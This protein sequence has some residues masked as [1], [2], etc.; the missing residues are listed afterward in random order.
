MDI[1]PQIIEFSVIAQNAKVPRD[2]KGWSAYL[3]RDRWD[4]WSSYCTQFYL[5]I[6]DSEGNH[7]EIGHVKIGQ[8]GLKAGSGRDPNLESL[9]RKP[10]MPESFEI[11]GEDFFSVGQDE[12]YY[13]NLTEIGEEVRLLVLVALKDV[14]YDSERWSWAKDEDVTD[15]SLLRS[16]TSSTV[17]GQ[18]RRLAN[19]DARVTRY[20]FS[21]IPPKREG[22]GERR[23]TLDFSVNPKSPIPTNIHVL[24]GRNGVGK[25][26]LLSLMT[27]ALVA[28]KAS[29]RQSGSFEMNEVGGSASTF[30]NVV[31]VSFSAFDDSE[32]FDDRKQGSDS[33][34]FA[35]I[36]LKGRRRGSSP[37]R[38]KSPKALADD[39]VKSL[40]ICRIGAR[41]NRWRDV[42]SIL[43]SDPI[44]KSVQLKSVIDAD[45]ED[46]DTCE[47]VFKIFSLLSSGHK[48]VLL[49][50]TRLVEKVEERTLVLIDEPEGHLHPP[51]LSA[52]TRAISG[53]M[54]RRNGVAIIATHSP[55]I[56]QEVPKSCVWIMNRTSRV[57]A[58]VR[59]KFETFAE[60]VGIL[61]REVFRL[62]LVRSGFYNILQEVREQQ[63]SYEG[64]INYFNDELGA[65]G[66]AILR[67]MYLEEE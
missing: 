12:E 52:M 14:A 31:A 51:L 10:D 32:F 61:T 13:Q 54:V 49:A 27:R 43:E 41:A 4:D 60:N 21:Y 57:A 67:A 55:V 35:Y 19:G 11:L 6:V 7:H 9:H 33:L 3:N 50:L 58:A 66:R 17:E 37:A 30:A 59:P 23:F 29:A 20:D 36:G 39:F 18:F 16:V 28:Q 44:F 2:A 26:R 63:P 45:L 46:E 53:L 56:L 47:R 24:I 25:T 65:E 22:D 5:T 15:T 40:R 1:F 38:P 42:I 62:E 8:K 64:A 48:I 34:G